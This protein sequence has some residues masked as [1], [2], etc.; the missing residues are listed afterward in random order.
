MISVII[1]E[2]FAV[3]TA[4]ID[5]AGNYVGNKQVNYD[6]RYLDDTTLTPPISGTFV[7]S[8]IASGIYVADISIPVAGEYICYI[9]S[10]GFPT[11]FEEIIVNSKDI[12]T[13]VWEHPTAQEFLNNVAFIKAIESGAWKI[14]NDQMIFLGQDNVTEI[15]VFDLFNELGAPADTDVRERKRLLSFCYN[16]IRDETGAIILDE[17]GDYL[18]DET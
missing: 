13:L 17:S 16:C 15:A 14:L 1:N 8:T 9:T 4:L 2:S 10:V 3:T 12:A 11:V 5:A 7:E 6:I 18:L